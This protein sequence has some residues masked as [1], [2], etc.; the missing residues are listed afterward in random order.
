MPAGVNPA[1]PQMD[2]MALRL[3]LAGAPQVFRLHDDVLKRRLTGNDDVSIDDGL[4]LE[5]K[6]VERPPELFRRDQEWRVQIVTMPRRGQRAQRLEVAGSDRGRKGDAR[7]RSGRD[8]RHESRAQDP[9]Q[10]LRQSI[11]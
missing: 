6:R 8:Q 10:I 4:V 11:E 1:L 9:G 3:H 2:Q 7:P 5:G